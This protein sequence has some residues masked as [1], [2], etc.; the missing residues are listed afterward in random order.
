M[1]RKAY[2]K[3]TL[4]S[5]LI[6]LALGGWLL[7]YRIHPPMAHGYDLIPFI[8]G[9]ITII[10]VP[11]LF[12]YRST[13]AY[14]FVINGFMVILGTITMAHFSLAHLSGPLT[15]QA[16]FFNTLLP[17]IL[18]LWGNFALGKALF[19]LEVLNTAADP[20]PP[21]TFWRYWRYPNNGWWLI[22]LVT[23]SL[24]Y[25]LGNILWR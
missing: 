1:N 3:A 12:C 5:G 19:D 13:Y 2:I 21:L 16:L 6:V 17:D 10:I 14:A 24:V 18:M 4:L 25:A 20:L 22:H 8:T 23:W 15:V 9:I 11:W 7:H